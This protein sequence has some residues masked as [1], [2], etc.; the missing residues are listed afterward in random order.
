MKNDSMVSEISD[1]SETTIIPLIIL[2]IV[3]I[4]S[5]I[6]AILIHEKRKRRILRDR[7]IENIIE[8]FL[9]EDK[10]ER[11]SRKPSDNN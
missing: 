7:A 2:F 11:N 5:L 9:L 1:S 6:L 4:S 3:V 10:L 8:T